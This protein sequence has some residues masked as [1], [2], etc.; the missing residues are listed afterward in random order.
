MAVVKSDNTYR[1][2]TWM[3]LEK[4]ETSY[5][6][7]ALMRDGG[8]VTKATGNPKRRNRDQRTRL[9]REI[10][11]Y[12]DLIRREILNHD[13]EAEETGMSKSHY[14]REL[15]P[16]QEDAEATINLSCLVRGNRYR[17]GTNFTC[18]YD[19]TSHG[20]LDTLHAYNDHCRKVLQQLI[21]ER[22]SSE[23]PEN[24]HQG[25]LQHAIQVEEAKSL[26]LPDANEVELTSE[27]IGILSKPDEEVEE[28]QKKDIRDKY[29][30]RALES[31]K[32][33]LTYNLVRNA[34][35]Y[36]LWRSKD[37]QYKHA[38]HEDE[39]QEETKEEPKEEPKEEHKEE[40]K[41]E[42]KEEPQ[43]ESKEEVKEQPKE[44]QP[45][46]EDKPRQE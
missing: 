12:L 15:S 2:F 33:L 21:D 6:N 30:E 25:N 10:R 11:C 22:C 9:I 35:L 19:G 44:E 16:E 32:K 1:R 18:P 17:I 43:E 3:G 4:A 45:K 26:K 39:H 34:N 42:S 37:N 14:K 24:V 38:S 8:E 31:A 28:G 5:E 23:G 29:E 36:G 41:E 13:L 40:P 46:D 7:T 27:E 20:C